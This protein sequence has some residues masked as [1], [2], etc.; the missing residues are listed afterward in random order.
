MG[1]RT[2]AAPRA[3]P[4]QQLDAVWGQRACTRRAR[5]G[6][7][8]GA[9]RGG[10][11]G[12]VGLGKVLVVEGMRFEDLD[13]LIVGYVDPV[14]AN[15][16]K[17]HTHT[18]ARAPTPP[19]RLLPRPACRPAVPPSARLRPASASPA[20]WSG[21]RRR[22]SGAASASSAHAGFGVLLNL[23]RP[24]PRDWDAVPWCAVVP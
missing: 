7:V 2:C 5:V 16:R 24:G 3:L 15:E 20:L 11:G 10:G 14:V 21:R 17:Y 9:W 8:D 18:R 12:Q 19:R 6:W 13:E 23:A 1:P 22:R 4:P